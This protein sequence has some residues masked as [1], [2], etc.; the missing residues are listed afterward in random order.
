MD[1]GDAG[2]EPA[3]SAEK[4]GAGVRRKETGRENYG[5][6]IQDAWGWC[7]GM[8]QRDDMGWEV[9]RGFGI[10]NS[11]TPVVDSCQCMAKLIQYCRVK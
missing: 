7:M 10:G 1:C 3:F 5:H 11:C 8:I 9:G 6:R 2:G 4:Q